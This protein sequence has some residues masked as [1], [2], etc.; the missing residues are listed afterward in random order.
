MR[1]KKVVFVLIGITLFFILSMIYMILSR[2]ILLSGYS[3]SGTV[4]LFV[5]GATPAV[6]IHSPLNTTYY[7]LP[8]SN[9][10]IDLNVSANQLIDTW[11]YDLEDLYHNIIVRSHVT[12]SPNT[13]FDAVRRS[14]RITVYAEHSGSVG[15]KN[16]TFYVSVPNSAPILGNI[17]KEIY[18]C[19]SSALSYWFNATDADED[20]LYVSVSP[21]GPFFVY[22]ST[23]LKQAFI[24]A[25]LFSGILTKSQVGRYSRIISIYDGQYTDSRGT[26]ITVIEI[27]NPPVISLIGVHT[28]YTRGDNRT[29]YKQ[30]DVNDVESGD[31]NSG[32]LFFNLT[33]LNAIKFFDISQNGTMYTEGNDSI[34]GVYNISVCVTDQ[35]LPVIPGNISLCNQTGSNMTICTNFSLTVT[36]ENRRPTIISFYPNITQFNAS[37]MQ[38]LY[39]NISTYDPDGTIPDIYWYV[40]NTLRRYRSGNSSDAFSFVFRCGISGQQIVKAEITDGLLNDSVSWNITLLNNLCPTPPMPGGGGGTGGGCAV[41]WACDSWRTCQNTELSLELGLISGEQYRQIKTQCTALHLNTSSC[42]LQIRACFDAAFC[43]ITVARP[44]LLQ[45][46]LYSENPSCYDRINNC[47]DGECELLV[48]CGG[49][50][51]V[52]ASCSDHKQNQGEQDIDCGG[53]CPY[54][55]P[56]EKPYSLF[57]NI[58]FVSILWLLLLLLL[59]FLIWL[60]YKVVRERIEFERQKKIAKVFRQ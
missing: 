39:F 52:C 41:K 8:G 50:C 33:F 58:Y 2:P 28:I 13:T 53:P 35:A 44:S 22:P 42:G 37:G 14:N 16:V 17:S 7:F 60:I 11:W 45:A 23:F 6:T 9:F 48:D 15:T 34:L 24:R 18:V 30:V 12:F 1:M 3:V 55:C 54:Q 5:L 19:E 10:T 31:E 27:N 36:N 46:C 49:P 57:D 32:K 26:N 38:S 21:T 29:F 59:L 4:G 51:P 43:N 56:T 20:T 25:E 47:H 40:N